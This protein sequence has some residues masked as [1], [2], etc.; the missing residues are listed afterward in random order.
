MLVDLK[1][2]GRRDADPPLR[3]RRLSLTCQKNEKNSPNLKQQPP[4][5]IFGATP[6]GYKQLISVSLYSEIKSVLTKHLNLKIE[7]TQV[8]LE[9]ASEEND[10]SLH[11]EIADGLESIASHLEQMELQLMLTGEFDENNAISQHTLWSRAGI[12]AQDWAGMLMRM[13]L[14][15]CDQRSY[16]TEIVDLAAGG[17]KPVLKARPS[18]L[19]APQPTVTYR[20]NLACIGSSGCPPTTSTN[21]DI[22]PSPPLTLCLKLMIPSRLTFKRK[23]SE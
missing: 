15:W 11:P 10:A 1:N 8:L 21:A 16:Q 14:R 6:N 3:N 2:A 12:D 20:L 22:P 5:Q 13:Y 4:R 7:D 19:K 23:T 18:S 17:M 9:L